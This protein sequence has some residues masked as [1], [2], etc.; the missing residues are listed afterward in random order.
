M[1]PREHSLSG[2]QKVLL[3]LFFF[4]GFAALLY[5]VV[6]QRWLVFYTGIGT[7]SISLIV[8]AYMVGLGSGYLA[9]GFLADRTS[10]AKTILY[11]VLAESGIGIFALFSKPFLYDF[12]YA[13]GILPSGNSFLQTY[14]VLFLS[15]LFP[16]FLMGLSLPFLTKA[17][18]LKTV[19][20]QVDFLNFLYFANTFGAA[21]GALVSGI[22]LMQLF[23][24]QTTIYFGVAINFFCAVFAFTI[25]AKEKKDDSATIRPAEPSTPFVWDRSFLLWACQYF[26]SGFAALSLEIVWFRILDVTIKSLSITFSILLAI[27]LFS[28]S[29]GTFVGVKFSQRQGGNNARLFLFAQY[30]LYIFTIGSIALLILSVNSVGPFAFV[31]DYFRSYDLKLEIQSL[32]IVIWVYFLIPIFLMSVPTFL[33][34][35]SF[36]ISQKIFQDSFKEIG[37]KVGYLQ[38]IN[39]LGSTLGTWFATFIGFRYLGSSLTVKLICSLGIL[40]LLLLAYR[41]FIGSRLFVACALMSVVVIAFLPGNNRF[42]QILS[43]IHDSSEIVFNEDETAVSSI[44]CAKDSKCKV[45][46]VIANGLGQSDLPLQSDMIH[47]LIGSIPALIHKNPRTIAVIGLGSGGT[48]FGISSRP[49]TKSI[50]CFEVITNQPATLLRYADRHND[51]TIARLLHDDRIAVI[52]KDGRYAIGKSL[53]KYDLIE[54]D[55]LRPL[56]SYSGNIY[57]QEYFHGL[58][59]NLAANGIVATWV[60]TDRVRKTFC[61][62]FPFVVEIK[63]LLLLGSNELFTVDRDSINQ[64]LNDRYTEKYYDIASIPIKETLRP[65][66]ENFVQLQAG[67]IEQCADINTDMFPRDEYA[68]FAKFLKKINTASETP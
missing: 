4:S 57:S 23:G 63:D 61:S 54:A 25:Y 15:L 60:P 19:G 38:A 48:L 36:S 6:W 68:Y 56:S 27:Y 14:V 3:F 46:Y 58:S 67:T 22:A 37:R 52:L 39:I 21:A 28:M 50:D 47:V 33:M 24:M 17:F 13:S 16:T 51:T 41:K 9:G 59:A 20:D 31:S 42:W 34:G 18:R 8:S 53:K 40:Y 7:V 66:L 64:R 32:P 45:H 55:A 65:F 2:R 49:E 43:G 30:S 62:V 26:I 5:Q 35:F 10:R 11:F 44:I 12:L 1:I 29:I